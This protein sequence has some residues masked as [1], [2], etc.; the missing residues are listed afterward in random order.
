MI[1]KAKMKGNQS[2]TVE[3]MSSLL[4]IVEKTNNSNER[5]RIRSP[6]RN[7]IFTVLDIVDQSHLQSQIT[8]RETNSIC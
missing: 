5:N 2:F 8:P 3:P 1:T 6:L 7:R 4:F